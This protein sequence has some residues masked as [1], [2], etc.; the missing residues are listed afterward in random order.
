ML[1][2]KI[3]SNQNFGIRVS[4][5]IK[6]NLKKERKEIIEKY[7]IDSPQNKD[8]GIKQDAVRAVFPDFY[9]DCY[10]DFLLNKDALVMVVSDENDKEIYSRNNDYQKYGNKIC[11]DNI[12]NFLM[13][14]IFESNNVRDSYKDHFAN[15]INSFHI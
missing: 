5:K 15:K 9:L 8:F 14:L 12:Y 1:V 10:D 7:G 2:Y 3:G 11:I 4:D 6:E 13:S